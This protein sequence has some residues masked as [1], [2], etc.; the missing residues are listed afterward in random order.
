ML[1]DPNGVLLAP[2][3]KLPYY[4]ARED[5]AAELRV[6]EGELQFS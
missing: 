6:Q 1:L 2:T 3:T 4:A 5:F